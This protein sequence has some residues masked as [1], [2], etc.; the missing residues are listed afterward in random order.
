MERDTTTRKKTPLSFLCRKVSVTVPKDWREL[1]Q[2]QLRYIFRLF[3]LYREAPDWDC[4]IK[5][6]ALLHFSS[7]EVVRRTEQGW[8]CRKT[9][10]KENFVLDPGLLPSLVE[11]LRWIADADHLSVHIETV[12]KYKAVD[13]QLQQLPFGEYLQAENWYQSFLLSHQEECLVKLGTILYGMKDGKGVEELKEEVL[14][15]TF[16][17]FNA[18]KQV[19]AQQ[20]PNFLKPAAGEAEVTREKLIDSMRAQIRLLT[21]GDVTKQKYILENTDTWTALAE[22]DALA[23][24]AEDIQK[25]YGKK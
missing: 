3:W 7:I 22:L 24:E 2:E 23:R 25:K 8:L 14:T 20:F 19:L 9:D 17:W 10:T 18:A 1:S 5:V 11:P 16:M 21:K 15:G 4:R 13:F 12:G 6:A